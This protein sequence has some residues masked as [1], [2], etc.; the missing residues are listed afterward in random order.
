MKLKIVVTTDVHG[1]IFP[2]NY[3]SRENLEDYGLARISTAVKQFRNEGNVL[4]LDNGD[5]FQGTPLLTYAHQHAQ[6]VTN[7]IAQCFNAMD[8]DFINLGNHDFNY[9]PEIL[10][11]YIN[12]NNAPLLTSNIEIEGNVPGSTQILTYEGKKI[13]LIGVLTQ[14]IPHWE[15]PAHIQNMSF[16]GAFE[17]LQ[18]EVQ[19][20]RN[21]VDYVIAMYHGGLER[22]P[23][24]GEPTERLTGENE[25]Y[26]MTDI[27]GLDILI[28]GHQHRSFIE[29]VN[30]VLVTQNT[31]KAKEFITIDLDLET[32]SADAQRLSAADYDIDQDL[33]QPLESLQNKTQT[34]LDQPVGTLEN[35]DVMIDDELDARLHKHPLVSLLNQI[36]LKR[37][38]AQISSVAL[39]N[40]AQGFNKSITM[41]E[42]VSTYLYPNT[43]V[44]K[45]MSGKALRE[46][47]EFSAHY[48]SLDGTHQIVPSPEYVEPK[49]Q[50]YNYDMLDGV[51]YTLDISKPRGS[52][53]VSLTY[54]DKPVLDTDEFTVVVNNYRAMGG[55]NYTMVAESETLDDIQ[56]EMVDVIMDY[57]VENSPV[58]VNHRDNIKVIAST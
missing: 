7:P 15:R 26:A 8:Y 28:T 21:D 6:T 56:E 27:E 23:Q 48:F 55:G 39:F 57:F 24:T 35:M 11:K 41:R 40:G 31:F 51:D 12:E 32:G 30:G 9:G 16:K 36:Q 22:D 46:M 47:I 37:S 49:P 38:G 3:T 20:V 54:Q 4:L 1:N 17:H 58:H 18:K 5:A 45:K 42:L 2:T 29:T 43:L 52:R 10:N 50:H 25:G 14:Y 53:V 44:V 34:W 33:L 19:R 13:A